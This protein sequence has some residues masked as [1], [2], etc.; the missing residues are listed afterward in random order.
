MTAALATSMPFQHLPSALAAASPKA[1]EAIA[2]TSK[3]PPEEATGLKRS[4]RCISPPGLKPCAPQG[5][6]TAAPWP[7]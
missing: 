4:V 3:P 2:P 6:P 1:L 7:T 5:C